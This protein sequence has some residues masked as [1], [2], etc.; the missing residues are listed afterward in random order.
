MC[1]T[2]PY[3]TW[4]HFRSLQS[5][6]FGTTRV[7]SYGDNPSDPRNELPSP[8]TEHPKL[9]VRV[10]PGAGRLNDRFQ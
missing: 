9:K 10:D 6:Q 5:P 2:S 1:Y 3:N 4:P 8:K 7:S